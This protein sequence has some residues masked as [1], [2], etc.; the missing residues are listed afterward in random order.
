M[1]MCSTG[2]IGIISAPQGGC[3][4][5]CAAVGCA[6]GSLTTLSVAA[7]KTAPHAMSEFYGYKSV[8]PIYILLI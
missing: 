6:S 3:S 8:L 4:S 1:A 2:A 5:I 7:G